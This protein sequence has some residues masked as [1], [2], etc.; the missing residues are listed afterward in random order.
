MRRRWCG[1]ARARKNPRLL[2]LR[3]KHRVGSTEERVL[4]EAPTDFRCMVETALPSVRPAIAS[5]TQF[6]MGRS[7]DSR[8]ERMSIFKACDIRGAFGTELTAE[9]A[10]ALGH[11]LAVH[12]K[13]TQVLVGGDGRLSTPVLKDALIQALVECGIRVLDLG[14]VPTPVFYYARFK[15]GIPVGVM[16]TAS[17]NPAPDN[18]FKIVLDDL[19]ITEAE[20]EAL[21]GLMESHAR[22]TA[23][24]P[25]EVQPT[26]VVADYAAFVKT[27][28][29][30]GGAF[31]IVVDSGN[32]ICGPIAPSLF[33]ALGY[34]VVELFS[35]VDGRFPNRPSNP[36]VRA[37]LAALV[38]CV[39]LSGAAL[40]IAYDGDGDRV[41]FVDERGEPV[42]NDRSIVLFAREALGRNPGATIVYDQKCS[43]VVRE[44]ILRGGGRPLIERSGHTFIKTTFLETR[45]AYAG[46]LSGHHFFAELGGD[47][48]LLASLRMAALLQSSGQTLAQLVAGIPR[49]PITPD[50]RLTVAPGEAATI[51]AGVIENVRDAIEISRLDGVRAR[52]PDGWGLVR[53]SVTEPVI[54][55]RFEGH[56][57]E[58][59]ERIKHEFVRAAPQLA[60][61]I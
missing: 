19:P 54:T 36:A 56:T 20:I 44:E 52:F 30:S 10:T 2:S 40:G 57:P 18:G 60:G 59:L 22:C 1:D 16:V 29:P 23:R 58:A 38:E 53:A 39:R 37:N 49:Y 41:A 61:R 43:D 12:A 27:L 48:G 55:L 26:P 11:A 47:D 35:E 31:K 45:A 34:E 21:G 32:G 7:S 14:L 25:G 24:G 5:Q 28:F 8:W 3:I 50:I 9:H 46:E 15:L 42:D 17:H 51:I 6:M 13:P 4:P 33:R